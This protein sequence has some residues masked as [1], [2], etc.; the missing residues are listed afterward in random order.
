MMCV[1]VHVCV[2][3][4]VHVCVCVCVCVCACVCA[5]VCV[6]V[7]GSCC[8]S[9]CHGKMCAFCCTYF[10]HSHLS[11][12][13]SPST[14]C[15][16]SPFPKLLYNFNIP[17]FPQSSFHSVLLQILPCLDISSSLPLFCCLLHAQSP[18]SYNNYYYN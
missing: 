4:C 10:Q 7:F 1:C 16:H 12:Y 15:P 13:C 6:H 5:C 11:L 18:H 3:V 9:S 14:P 17:S 8:I 2:C